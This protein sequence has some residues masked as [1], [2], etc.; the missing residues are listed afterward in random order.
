MVPGKRSPGAI[1]AVHARGEADQQDTGLRVAKGRHGLAEVVRVLGMHRVEKSGEAGTAPAVGIVDRAGQLLPKARV[2]HPPLISCKKNG[3]HGAPCSPPS[4]APGL[5]LT[6]AQPN[7][8]FQTLAALRR[9][10]GRPD[11]RGRPL[12]WTAPAIK[13]PAPDQ[14]IRSIRAASGLAGGNDLPRSK[15]KGGKGLRRRIAPAPG[16]ATLGFPNCMTQSLW[17]RD[18][19]FILLILFSFYSLKTGAGMTR[20]EHRELQGLLGIEPWIDL[21]AVGACKVRLGQPPRSTDA[22]RDVL[23]GELDVHP[24]EHRAELLV[25]AKGGLHFA[26]DI[27]EPARLDASRGGLGIAV[28]GIAHP[29]NLGTALA[30]RADHLGQPVLNLPHAEAMNEGQPSGLVLRIEDGDQLLQPLLIHGNADFEPD[31]VRDAAKVFD[32]CAADLRGAHADPG[33]VRGE[34]VPLP[35]PLDV[36]RLSLL[37]EQVKA[38]VTRVEIDP[39]GGMH[40]LPAHRLEELERL[41]DR[42]DDLLVGVTQRR[43]AHESQIPVLGMM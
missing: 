14:I 20:D 6:R 30:H 5:G 31:G 33:H 22:L 27:V 36:A 2:H 10:F 34:V 16:L 8:A 28:H 25:N 12:R 13:I 37:A 11:P 3:L 23:P 17:I 38:L 7:L 35:L 41:G 19:I 42:V 1:R 43:M 26:E 39:G 15:Y 4:I 24:P 21:R 29:E 9:P 40:R 18:C 32:V